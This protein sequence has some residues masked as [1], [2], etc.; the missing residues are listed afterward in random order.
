MKRLSR[1]T[2]FLP[3]VDI[4]F[5]NADSVALAKVST[6]ALR[7]QAKVLELE[8]MGNVSFVCG[9]GAWAVKGA[10]SKL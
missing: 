9:D 8:S 5:P 10:V 6:L 1:H 7:L 4:V 3:R 2:F